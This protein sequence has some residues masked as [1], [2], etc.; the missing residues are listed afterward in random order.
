L[1][2]KPLNQVKRR[3]GRG[4][5]RRLGYREE[6]KSNVRAKAMPPAGPMAE[7]EIGQQFPRNAVSIGWG[8]RH[9]GGSQTGGRS[10]TARE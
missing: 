8:T 9:S 10:G 6:V 1:N 3:S 5:H 7:V 4:P 2:S